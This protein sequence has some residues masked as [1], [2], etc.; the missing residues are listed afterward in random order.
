MRMAE[1]G[2]MGTEVRFIDG[3]L[4]PRKGVAPLDALDI[5]TAVGRLD[6]AHEAE[7]HQLR[8]QRNRL[9]ALVVTTEAQIS[10][11]AAALEM[12]SGP[13]DGL[14]VVEIQAAGQSVARDLKQ[15]AMDLAVAH[16]RLLDELTGEKH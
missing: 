6:Q 14:R 1:Y 7:T 8:R 9:H 15:I 10:E 3:N 16:Q 13:A 12:V 2:E 4:R 11:A 5:R